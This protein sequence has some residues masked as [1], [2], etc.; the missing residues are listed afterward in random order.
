MDQLIFTYLSIFPF[1]KLLGI[2]PDVIILFICF[3]GILRG[4]KFAV[5]NYLLVILFSLFFSLSFFKLPELVTGILY[6]VRL[7]SYIFFCQVIYVR[8]GKTKR[9]RELMIN[10]LIAVGIFIAIFG[11]IQY[12]IFPDLRALKEMGWDDHY[13]RLTSTFL[14][15]AFTGILLVLTETLILAKTIQ[16]RTKFSFILNLFLIVTIAFTYSR[17]SFIALIFVIFVLFLKF[18][19]TF[20]LFFLA[21]FV[22]IIPFLPQPPSEGVHLTRT[23]SINQKFIN[24][25][26]SIKLIRRSP[27]LGI[28]FDNLCVAKNKFLGTGN[29]SSHTCSGLDNGFLF[30]LATTGV[31]GLIIFIQFIFSIIKNTKYDYLGWGLV[32]SLGAIFIHGM[33]TNTFFYNFVL[34]WVGILIGV[35]RE[36]RFKD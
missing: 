1:G 23:Y 35:T 21:F 28:G 24:Y 13:F 18:K 16:K 30:I 15:P 4:Y 25:D 17:A 14:D 9:K 8:F 7:T 2:L 3:F 26:E 6:F 12:V 19:K 31:V 34:G 32:V 20:L 22:L 29:S 36:E 11:W 10:S 27:V 5:N 33:F